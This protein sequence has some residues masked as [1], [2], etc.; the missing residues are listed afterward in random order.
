[1]LYRHQEILVF[2]LLLNIRQKYDITSIDIEFKC[3]FFLK[4]INS[5]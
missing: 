2:T 5:C 1:M 3:S 4:D